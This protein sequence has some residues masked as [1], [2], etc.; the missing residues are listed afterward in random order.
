[1][2]GLHGFEVGFLVGALSVLCAAIWAF[3][4]VTCA[5]LGGKRWKN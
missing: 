5:D 2:T 3:R 4:R 1:M